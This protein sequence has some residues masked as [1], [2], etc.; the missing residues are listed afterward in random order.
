MF[1]T[2]P[3]NFYEEVRAAERFILS[4][5][6]PVKEMVSG[7]HGRNYSQASG[8]DMDPTPENDAFEWLAVTTPKIIH[9]NPIIEVNSRHSGAPKD[10]ILRLKHAMNQWAN[11]HDLWR[12]L[13]AVWYDM[14]FGFGVARTSL[15]NMPGY[16]GY[17]TESGQRIQPQWPV[18]K[19]VSPSRFIL[20]P[21]CEDPSEARFMGHRWTRDKGD[22]LKVKGFDHD[23][24][25]S[26]P[27]DAGMDHPNNSSQYN[28]FSSPSREEITGYEIW[29]PEHTLPEVAGDKRY[30]GTLFTMAIAATPRVDGSGSKKTPYWVRK[31]R[32]FFGPPSGPYRIFGAYLVPGNPLPLSPLQATYEQSKELNAHATSAARG[33]ARRKRFVAF[34]PKNPGAG[35]AAKNAEHGSVIP[36]ENL[37]DDLR[38]ITI[39]GVEK[40]EYEYL[41]FLRSRNDRV[42]GLDEPGRGIV[43]GRGAA[44]EHAIANESRERR[45][46]LIARMFDESCR[47]VINTAG[48]YCF[49]SEFV[50]F[51]L[52]ESAVGDLK[53]RPKMLPSEQK[54]EEIA[55][56]V[57]EPGAE[58]P[59]QIARLPFPERLQAIQKSL[60]W[61]PDIWFPSEDPEHQFMSMADISGLNYHE[62]ELLIEPMSMARTDQSLLQRRMQET[63]QLVTQAALIM[64]QTPYI[65]WDLLFD[66]MGHSMNTRDLSEV[67]RTDVL[68]AFQQQMQQAAGGA[69]GEGGAAQPGSPGTNGNGEMPDITRARQIGREVSKGSR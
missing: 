43:T 38:E 41:G 15:G 34:D 17:H 67:L 53:P 46:A 40:E 14:A 68:Q 45:N 21:R 58:D 47:V 49:H 42:K 54:A 57:A 36:I 33:A 9:D 66:R 65:D 50:R 2:D 7:Y 61:E 27:D 55:L 3:V 16:D 30:N 56:R 22:L 59:F 48:W 10:V 6:E 35:K 13:M 19:R 12:V 25:K 5:I 62:L 18:V 4:H 28:A 24:I 11:M 26:I 23:L 60:K 69:A 64:P 52:G 44:T 20:D 32:P 8:D 1:Q 29:V 39:G 63:M 37:S 51:R 31:P